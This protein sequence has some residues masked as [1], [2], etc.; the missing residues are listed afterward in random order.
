MNMKFN[1]MWTNKFSGETGFVGKVAKSKGYF[2]NAE[3]ADK[4][5]TYASAKTAE[6]DITVLTELGEAEN[7]YFTVVEAVTE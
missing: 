4:A 7:N 3:T 2:V 6:K 5:K 1:L